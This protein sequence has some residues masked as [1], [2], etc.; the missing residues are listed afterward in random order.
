[1]QAVTLNSSYFKGKRYHSHLTRVSFTNNDET[2]R[3]FFR[4]SP[5]HVTYIYFSPK[6]KREQQQ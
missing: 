4:I 1:M 6:M 3:S 2:S 5:W